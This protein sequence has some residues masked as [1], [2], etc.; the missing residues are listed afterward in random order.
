MVKGGALANRMLLALPGENLERLRS[1]LRLVELRRRQ[2]IYAAGAP[3]KNVYFVNRGLVSLVKS[4]ADGRSVE[5]GTIG[6]EGAVCL[7]I[8]QGLRKAILESVVQIPGSALVIGADELCDAMADD[9]TLRR[10]LLDYTNVA[11]NQIA[12]TAACNRLH[13]LEERCCRWL[14]TAHDSAQ[15]DEFPLTHEFLAMMLGVRRSGLSIAVSTL[16]KA[17]FI[18]YRRGRVRIMD[19]AGLEGTTCECYMAIRIQLDEMYSRR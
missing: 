14:L 9:D 2:V 18:R 3:A 5:V 13:T 6:V 4:M 11:I 8:L 16:Q 1:G 10:L 7:G 15:S 17:G 19:R 12:Q